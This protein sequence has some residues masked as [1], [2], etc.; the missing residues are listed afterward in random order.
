MHSN[1]K[2]LLRALAREGLDVT[3]EDSIY[4]I[5]LV[6][7]AG[8]PQAEVLLPADLPVEAKALKQLAQLAALR[9]PDGSG[10][11][12]AYAT[13]DFHPGDSGVAIGSVIRT[14][15]LL[16]PAA[17]GTDINCGMRLHVFDVSLDAFL[18]RRDDFVERMKGDFFFG[19]RDLPF[20]GATATAMFHDGSEGWLPKALKTPRG[21]L[22]Q[23][24]QQQLTGEL[25]R[26]YARGSLQ[27]DARWAPHGF[28]PREGLGRD[29]SLATIGGGNHFVEVQ[30]IEEI[31]DRQRA[32]ELGLRTG[33]LTFMIHSGSRDVG[34]HIGVQWAQKAK[35]AWPKGA[36]YPDGGILPI[37]AKANPELAAEYLTAEATAANYGF[38]NRLLLAELVRL[39]LR[40]V[41]G[42]VEAPLIYDIPHNITLREYDAYVARKGA[43][44]AHAGQLVIIPGS[45]G[46]S[47]YLLV[48]L[49][50]ERHLSSAS[51]GAGR[52]QS[53]FQMSRGGATKNEGALGLSGV[54]CVSLREERRIEE[55]PAAYKPI[56]PVIDSQVKAG[57]VA[58]VARMRPILTFK[59]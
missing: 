51:H 46:A 29:A 30:C 35:D 21:R 57:V 6:G 43:C 37:S 17:V 34:K 4:R 36:Q 48:G 52:A 19:K 33:Q 15:D 5:R 12:R 58:V 47:S 8:F 50:S 16:V 42:D 7:Q 32:W 23:A 53:R 27:G 41:H 28:I 59:A 31:V 20:D 22:V 39:R 14:R 25:D 13:P 45:M 11:E 44:P 9:H 49:G 1:L 56:G 26:V 54:D 38:V 55:A 2:R 10:V 24:D 18:S 40:E 3:Y